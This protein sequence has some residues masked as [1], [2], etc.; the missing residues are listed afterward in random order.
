MFHGKCARIVEGDDVVGYRLVVPDLFHSESFVG[1]LGGDYITELSSVCDFMAEQA[2]KAGFDVFISR[3]TAQAEEGME[4]E[5]DCPPSGIET[6]WLVQN[7]ERDFWR[8][9]GMRWTS[10]VLIELADELPKG[11]HERLDREWLEGLAKAAQAE[12]SRV[13]R[14]QTGLIA[15]RKS[16]GYPETE[17]VGI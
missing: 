16:L 10:Y 3:L 9:E 2:E 7:L 15:F 6:D 8:M 11:L 14:E 1:R 4:V 13:L 17:I 12:M 5:L